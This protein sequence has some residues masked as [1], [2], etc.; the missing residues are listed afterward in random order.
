HLIPIAR[1]GQ[2]NESNW[3]TTS[4]LRNSAKSNWTIDEIGWELF[5]KG[6]LENWDGLLNYFIELTDK[7]PY[8]ERDNYVKNW[9]VGLLKAMSEL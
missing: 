1:G 9:K 2:D 7:N 5:N 4:M 3:I 8:Y 6:K